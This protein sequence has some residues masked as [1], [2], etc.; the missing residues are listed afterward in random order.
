MWRHPVQCPGLAQWGQGLWLSCRLLHSSQPSK[1]PLSARQG[2]VCHRSPGSGRPAVRVGTEAFVKCTRG[3]SAQ[4]V[5]SV[6]CRLRS[7]DPA[8]TDGSG[9]HR[10]GGHTAVT[11]PLLPSDDSLPHCGCGRPCPWLVWASSPATASSSGQ[12]VLPGSGS[13]SAVHSGQRLAASRALPSSSVLN[14]MKT[15][16]RLEQK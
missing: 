6:T 4:A 11:R 1:G 7:L 3:T 9:H 5:L 8:Q 16:L 13:P 12:H 2:S 10:P 14:L 15:V